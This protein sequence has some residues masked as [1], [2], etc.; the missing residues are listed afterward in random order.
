MRMAGRSPPSAPAEVP[1]PSVPRHRRHHRSRITAPG[2][3]ELTDVSPG[4]QVQ[5]SESWFDGSGCMDPDEPRGRRH[6]GYTLHRCVAAAAVDQQ[7]VPVNRS[8]YRLDVVRVRPC[9]P[10][11]SHNRPRRHGTRDEISG[12][13]DGRHQS[14][15]RKTAFTD[16]HG[17]VIRVDEQNGAAVAATRYNY[18]GAD[19][20]YPSS[21]IS[22]TSHRS[23]TTR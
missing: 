14:G 22:A 12:R 2:F 7:H 3:I 16:G 1:P 8:T 23:N 9:R 18:D 15:H 4:D 13:S 20:W 21:I 5:W 19:G 11:H 6:P 10:C 17:H